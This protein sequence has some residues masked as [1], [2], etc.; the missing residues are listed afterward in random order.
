MVGKKKMAEVGGHHEVGEKGVRFKNLFR[1]L[2]N[3]LKRCQNDNAP[4]TRPDQRNKL[5]R[6][7]KRRV[8]NLPRVFP[9]S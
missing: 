9:R 1:L 7:L 2:V 4:T 5:S 3:F 8:I 6:Y